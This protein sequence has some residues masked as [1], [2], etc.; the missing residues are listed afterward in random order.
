MTTKFIFIKLLINYYNKD[1]FHFYH[2]PCWYEGV[3]SYHI[4]MLFF[5][6]IAS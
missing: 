3:S 2:L 6:D 5:Y 1:Y 4:T